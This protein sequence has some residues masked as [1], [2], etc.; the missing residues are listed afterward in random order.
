[1]A[2]QVDPHNI[3]KHNT[4]TPTKKI[5]F[6]TTQND[7]YCKSFFEPYPNLSEYRTNN[8]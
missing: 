5:M 7:T 2:N 3:N 4:C 6:L 8:K 1:M